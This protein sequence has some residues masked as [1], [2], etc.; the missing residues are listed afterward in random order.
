MNSTNEVTRPPSVARCIYHRLHICACMCS[1]SLNVNNFFADLKWKI[2]VS[3]THQLMYF[4]SFLER[5]C[6]ILGNMLD[7]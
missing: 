3:M 1:T 6:Q 2:L 5:N 4:N 7:K